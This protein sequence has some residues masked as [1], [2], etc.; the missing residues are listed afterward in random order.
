[1]IPSVIRLR[2]HP[3][4]PLS[5]ATGIGGLSS[6]VHNSASEKAAIYRNATRALRQRRKG[7]CILNAVQLGQAPN[8]NL[9]SFD[10]YKGPSKKSPSISLCGFHLRVAR[11]NPVDSN[12][13][14]ATPILLPFKAFV[15]GRTRRHIPAPVSAFAYRRVAHDTSF[16]SPQGANSQPSLPPVLM[17]GGAFIRVSA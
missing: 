4:V 14:T 15:A 16:Y 9:F 11:T 8:G 10:G 17:A 6:F 12:Q 2:A 1:M 7:G 3:D 13:A 5:P